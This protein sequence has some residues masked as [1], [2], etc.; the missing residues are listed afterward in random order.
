MPLIDTSFLD[1]PVWAQ[2]CIMIVEGVVIAYIAQRFY[3]M[4]C[5]KPTP[6]LRERLLSLVPIAVLLSVVRMIQ[7]YHFRT[8]VHRINMQRSITNFAVSPGPSSFEPPMWPKIVVLI[9]S[10]LLILSI[11]RFLFYQYSRK[12][13]PPLQNRLSS[14]ILIGLMLSAVLLIQTCHQR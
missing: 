14:L 12:P 6:P 1:Y 11:C 13:V 10:A 2:N 3:Y 5:R 9:L 8:V 7:Q 4:F